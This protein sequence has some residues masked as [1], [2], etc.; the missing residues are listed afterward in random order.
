M[1]DANV[2]F[3]SKPFRP[4]PLGG[5]Q[6]TETRPKPSYTENPKKARGYAA[7][8]FFSLLIVNL[9]AFTA[10]FVP[11]I[12]GLPHFSLVFTQI[13][14]LTSQLVSG[15]YGSLLVRPEA[16]WGLIASGLFWISAYSDLRFRQYVTYALAGLTAV[17]I[18]RMVFPPLPFQWVESSVPLVAG[19]ILTGY[20]IAAAV[21]LPRTAR[22]PHHTERRGTGWAWACLLSGL[23]PLAVGRAICNASSLPQAPAADFGA[24]ITSPS[25]PW[26]YLVGASFIAVVWGVLQFVPPWSALRPVWP[27]IAILGGVMGMVFGVPR[28]QEGAAIAIVALLQ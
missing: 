17:L 7:V 20:T 4:T 24:M 8:A 3:I 13:D 2:K 12:S 11:E 22:V 16:I 9:L 1:S 28:A 15:G 14:A 27:S 5:A 23:V 6:T 26:L 10:D 18:L 21:R 25:T 19:L